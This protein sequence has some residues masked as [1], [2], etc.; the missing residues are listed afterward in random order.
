MSA[1]VVI[2]LGVVILLEA[3]TRRI[4]LNTSEAGDSATEGFVPR[5]YHRLAFALLGTALIGWGI[6]ALWKAR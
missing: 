5:W 1:Y 6:H 4:F 2:I 3:L